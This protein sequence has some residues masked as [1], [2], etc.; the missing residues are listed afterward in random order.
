MDDET[1]RS[2]QSCFKWLLWKV[3]FMAILIWW[4]VRRRAFVTQFKKLIRNSLPLHFKSSFNRLNFRGAA[5]WKTKAEII[6]DNL[7]RIMPAK[8]ENTARYPNFA[9]RKPY[10]FLLPRMFSSIFNDEKIIFKYRIGCL[11]FC[12]ICAK[13][14]EI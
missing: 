6:P 8:G 12:F 10:G 11:C 2:K 5:V 13:G 7:H 4:Y 14:K 3:S 1:S 9:V